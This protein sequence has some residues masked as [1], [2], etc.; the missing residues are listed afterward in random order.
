MF[1][2]RRKNPHEKKHLELF[3]FSFSLRKS[4]ILIFSIAK[5]NILVLWMK[6]K[7]EKF[8]GWKK[9]L[10][11]G[12]KSK[13]YSRIL[14]WNWKIDFFNN[15]IKNHL[16]VPFQNCSI[17]LNDA[18][19]KSFVP[20]LSFLFFF[21]WFFVFFFRRGYSPK[22]NTSCY[23]ISLCDFSALENCARS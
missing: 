3:L 6:E 18:A 23:A 7:T 1:Q 12:P 22:S 9:K 14:K 4:F 5:K 16:E 8:Y 10:K 13:Y 15:H 17:T 19:S 11:L 20:V 2:R 21:V